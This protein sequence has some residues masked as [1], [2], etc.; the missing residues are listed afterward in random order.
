MTTPPI[1]EKPTWR[2]MLDRA[3][4]TFLTGLLFLLPFILTLMILDWVIRQI[5]GLFGEETILGSALTGGT[6][7]IFGESSFG[8]WVVLALLVIA[9]WGVGRLFQNRA[10]KSVEARVDGW[11]DRIPVIGGIYRPISRL[12]RM[13]GLRDATELSSMRV[14]ACRFGGDAG[15]DILA[16]QPSSEPLI[17]GGEERMLIYMPS[18]PLP[19][20]GAIVLV[21]RASVIEV[22]G[23]A[24]DD[25][26]KYYISLGTISP[27]RL[28]RDL[29]TLENPPPSLAR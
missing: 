22:E 11:F 13:I 20:T 12:V 8:V 3:V 10:K 9:I 24:V 16:L 7:L 29:K 1:P 14:V 18:A 17:V 26:L 25:L 15:A 21:P 28:A 19:M 2:I 6:S 27:G 5:A 23:V 4:G